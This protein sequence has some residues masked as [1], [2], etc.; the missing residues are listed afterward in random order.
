MGDIA[1]AETTLEYTLDE[2]SIEGP[3]T[4]PAG[5]IGLQLVNVGEAPHE[6]IVMRAESYESL[7]KNEHGTVDEAQLPADAVIG[8]VDRFPGGGETCSGVFDLQPGR[9]VLVCNIEF[10]NGPQV[11]SHAGRGMTLDLEVTP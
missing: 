3:A 8:E 7:P 6:V 9:Y 4:V 2:F 10:Q 5:R 1:T 11:I